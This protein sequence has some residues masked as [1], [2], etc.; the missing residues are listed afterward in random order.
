MPQAAREALEDHVEPVL[1]AIVDEESENRRRL[2]AARSAA[3][4]G[5]AYSNPDPLVP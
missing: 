5:E 1:R 3:D 2:F 4:Y